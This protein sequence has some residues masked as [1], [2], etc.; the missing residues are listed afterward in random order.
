M[1]A[2]IKHILCLTLV[3]SIASCKKDLGSYNYSTIDSVKIKNIGETYTIRAGNNPKI[4]PEI[5][6]LSGN[7][8][9]ATDYTFQWS[10]YRIGVDQA[11]AIVGNEATLDKEVALAIGDYSMYYTIKEKATNVTWTRRFTLKVT[12]GYNGGWMILADDNGKSRLDFFEYDHA[13]A[14]YP[15]VHRNFQEKIQ[16]AKGNPIDISGKPKFLTSWVNQTEATGT[17]QKYFVY[18]GTDERTEKAN[19][20]DGFI[21]SDQYAFKYETSNAPMFET[22]DAIVPLQARDTY[23]IKGNDVYFKLAVYQYTV[24]TPINRLPDGTYFKAAPYVAAFSNFIP[25]CLMYDMTNKRFVRNG[26]FAVTAET[27]LTYDETNSAFNPNKVGMDLIWMNQ[28][29]AFGGQAYAVLT[30]DNRFYLAR[31]TNN[32]GFDARFWNEITNLPEIKNATR[33]E[34]DPRFGYLQYVVGGKIYQYDPSDG[35][36]KLMKDYGNR[37][38]TTFKYL[39]STYISYN[40]VINANNANTYGKRFLPNVIGLIVAT[41]DPAAPQTSGKVDI[42]ETPQFNADYKTFFSFDGFGKVADVTEAEFPLGW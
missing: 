4:V 11:P 21:W 31:M 12:S 2:I 24:G 15:K 10:A 5:S 8:F 22:V 28:T 40:T 42:L 32:S 20:T 17:G 30:K 33:F 37:Q 39:R 3:V 29:N 38:I 41:I 23:V 35:T 19:L 18:I 16:D 36:T 27:P 34:V 13:T 25:S 14:T 7:A 26:N 6:H 9:N 1:K